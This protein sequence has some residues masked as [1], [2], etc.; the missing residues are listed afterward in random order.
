MLKYEK[1]KERE[2]FK[3]M[4]FKEKVAHIFT[5]YRIPII[6]GVLGLI[7]LGWALNHYVI[8]PPKKPS[9]QMITLSDDGLYPYTDVMTKVLNERLPQ[10]VTDRT[11]ILAEAFD[12]DP[13]DSSTSYAYSMKMVAMCEAS[14]LDLVVGKKD[15]MLL[16]AG[17]GMFGELTS[18]YSTAELA[19]MNVLSCGLIEDVDSM[20]Q[21]TK[22]SE[23]QPYLIELPPIPG[24][25]KMLYT[26][27]PIYV[28]IPISS[29]RADNAKIVID[30]LLSD[31]AK[32]MDFEFTLY[33]YFDSREVDK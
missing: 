23:E 25:Q 32:D 20:G 19:K 13:S 22:I 6:A 16:Y 10:L 21:P 27:E 30:Y 11:E 18:Y 29:N 2:A 1:E 3:T 26:D 28:G 9:V 14:N 17:Q 8:H 15:V 4:T 5:Y 24:M 7:V 31:A 12:I 33:E